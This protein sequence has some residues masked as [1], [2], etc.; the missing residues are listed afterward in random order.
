MPKISDRKLRRVCLRLYDDDYVELE[1]LAGAAGEAV[2]LVIREAVHVYV[3]HAKD[4]V[5]E[6]ID[7]LPK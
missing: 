1:K 6:R 3:L 2:N 7:N 4:K 5:R